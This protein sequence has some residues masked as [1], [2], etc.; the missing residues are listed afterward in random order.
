MDVFLHSLK[1]TSLAR[2]LIVSL[3]VSA[4]SSKLA[5]AVNPETLEILDK[6]FQ[7]FS[8]DYYSQIVRQNV[9]QLKKYKTITGLK[10]KVDE[11][12][13]SGKSSQAIALIHY[14][15]NTLRD[16]IDALELIPLTTL[17]LDY[18][19][20]H[21]AKAILDIA[22]DEAGKS[23]V[24]RISFEFAKY[25]MKRKKWQKALDHLH[26]VIN[27]LSVENAN[28]AHLVIGT[29]LQY[30]KKHRQAVKYYKK[31]NPTS[32]YYSTAVLN[33]AVAYI[34][35][36]WW[37]DA[38]ILINK[39]I[40]NNDGQVS[41]IMAD[42][43]NL[44]LGYALLRKQYYRNSRDVFRNISLNS[45]Y[46]NRALLGIVLTAANQEDFIGSLNAI[47]IL[48][49]KRTTD[50]PVDESYLLLPYTY[51]KLKQYLTASSA[52]TDAMKYYQERIA[53][54]QDIVNS[55]HNILS[56]VK[57]SRK[58]QILHIKSN[59][60]D[61]SRQYPRSFFDNYSN[62]MALEN[63][64]SHIN[65]LNKQ[66]SLLARNYKKSLKN[67]TLQ[68]V[69]QRIEYLQSY[70]NQSRYGLARL[71]DSSLVSAN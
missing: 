26:D 48:K 17:L 30:Q 6:R 4:S 14:N 42:R 19:D 18:N 39:T 46:T 27:E 58:K 41:D 52:Y 32:K 21:E 22:R 29:I 43:L 2:I 63:N 69:S 25:F 66:Y 28:Y 47:R 55:G 65:N 62:L 40:E 9:F 60:L 54:L 12:I 7:Q 70:L 44:V 50:L 15:H 53:G 37:T 16:N 5:A 34:R 10:K 31:I 61:Y 23:A 36:D 35:Q 68:L 49:G 56:I 24:S 13:K 51:G 20:W 71:Y 45:P 33:T 67:I 38:H 59:D 8:Q 1:N 64:S 57:I 3:L 11:Y